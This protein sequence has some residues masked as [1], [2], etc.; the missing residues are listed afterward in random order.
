MIVH[1]ILQVFLNMLWVIK[2]VEVT[3]Y[4]LKHRIAK[5]PH[6]KTQYT[7]IQH[8]PHHKKL[9]IYGTRLHVH[10]RHPYL[11]ASP[12][13]IVNC[14]CHGK[15]CVEIQC[16]WLCR[17]ETPTHVNW[18]HLKS[19]VNRSTL[20]KSLLYYYQVKDNLLSPD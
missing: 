17:S 16:P 14:G 5:E 4:A 19:N 2:K 7:Y 1:K 10:P 15:G 13:L 8:Q 11:A 20:N 9:T 6:A 12:D 3:T 18:N